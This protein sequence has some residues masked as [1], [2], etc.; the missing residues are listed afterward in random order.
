MNDV[1]RRLR[2]ANVA[3]IYLIHGTFAGVD[4]LG[5]WTQLA[6]LHAPFADW[7]RNATKNWIDKLASDAGNYS[8]EYVA[9]FDHGINDG[10]TTAIPVQR[11]N[12]SSENHHIGRADGAIR[13]LEELARRDFPENARV[14]CW[15]HSHAGNVLALVTNLLGADREAVDEFF[16]KTRWYYRWPILGCCDALNWIRVQE[17]L[18]EHHSGAQSPW[19]FRLDAVTFGAPIRYGWN[20]AGYGQLAHF[21]NHR[22]C[23]GLEEYLAPFPPSPSNILAAIDGDYV[24]QLGIAGTNWSPGLLSLRSWVADVRL[25]RWLERGLEPRRLASRWATGC[26]VG[27]HGKTYLVE[28]GSS[29]EPLAR[30]LAGH[31]VYTTLPWLLFHAET[32]VNEFYPSQPEA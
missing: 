20:A 27:E 13:F 12:W 17:L 26:R 2:Q 6:R 22:P 4:G 25:G 23:Q 15:G 28:Y 18:K 9:A 32:V 11:F 8:E 3:A 31:A 10:H 16:G 24:Q 7:L 29:V 14:L 19:P 30:H 1:G 5:V 21:V